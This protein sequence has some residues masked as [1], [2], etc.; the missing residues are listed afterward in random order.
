M[1]LGIP[2]DIRVA[3][4]YAMSGRGIRKYD[5]RLFFLLF[6]PPL[7]FSFAMS[8]CFFL[9]MIFFF[10]FF[11]LS[12][13]TFF[14]G[15]VSIEDIAETM[16]FSLPHSNS[17]VGLFFFFFFPLLSTTTLFQGDFLFKVVCHI[18]ATIIQ[19]ASDIYCTL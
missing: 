5:R 13:P 4:R 15:L 19:P 2:Y 18:S 10:P 12:S 1:S 9:P 7:L 8:T 6:F 16:C 11:P 3:G 14:A 17:H